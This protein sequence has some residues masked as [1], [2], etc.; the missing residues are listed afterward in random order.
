VREITARGYMV[1]RLSEFQLN[2]LHS[3]ETKLDL[4]MSPSR[5]REKFDLVETGEVPAEL[6]RETEHRCMGIYEKARANYRGRHTGCCFA[7]ENGGYPRSDEKCSPNPDL[8]VLHLTDKEIRNQG[9][10][11]KTPTSGGK[12]RRMVEAVDEL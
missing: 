10:Q 9:L 2:E 12:A 6:Y 5:I 1:H 11:F 3:H 7:L 4:P 8:V